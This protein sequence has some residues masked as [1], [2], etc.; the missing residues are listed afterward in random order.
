[1]VKISRRV[2]ARA[3]TEQCPDFH[4]AETLAAALGL[5]AER[6]LSDQRVRTDGAHVNLVLDHVVQLQN[7]H[8]SDGNRLIEMFAGATIAQFHL[9]L[10]VEAGL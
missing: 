6:L 5:A 1:M 9:A 2:Y 10:F 4:F 8:V 3:V 7:I